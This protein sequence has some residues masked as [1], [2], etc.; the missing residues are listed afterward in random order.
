M[1]A[2]ASPATASSWASA[3]LLTGAGLGLGSKSKSF[4]KAQVQNK[5]RRSRSVV[6]GQKFSASQNVERAQARAIDIV[7]RTRDSHIRTARGSDE[8]G[9]I[10]VNLIA[11]NVDGRRD[12]KRRPGAY[13]HEWTQ[14][15]HIRQSDASAEKKAIPHV[16][17][18][19]AVILAY[20]VGV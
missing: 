17:R 8:T 2:A 4:S 20:V 15:K 6:D 5:M 3:L 18:G 13:Y 1:S 16:E 14:T 9:T 7:L 19:P 12:V 10:V 11:I